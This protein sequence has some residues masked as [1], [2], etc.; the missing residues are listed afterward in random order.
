M[1]LLEELINN[2]KNPG[3]ETISQHNLRKALKAIM[4]I[5]VT[6]KDK[7]QTLM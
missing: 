7:N 3:E 5:D 4:N 2:L 1:K 6:Y